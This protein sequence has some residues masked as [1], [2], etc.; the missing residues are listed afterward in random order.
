M[1]SPVLQFFAPSPS[2]RVLRSGSLPSMLALALFA[3]SPSARGVTS[4]P[5]GGYPNQNTAEG[6]N[7]L[8][9]LTSGNENTAIGFD[10][11][12]SNNSGSKNAATGAYALFS[13]RSA[14]NT[15]V[16]ARSLVSNTNG[17]WNTAI[18]DIALDSQMS[19]DYNLRCGVGALH[20]NTNGVANT[21]C[22][23]F[24]LYFNEGSSNSLLHCNFLLAPGGPPGSWWGWGSG[25]RGNRVTKSGLETV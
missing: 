20:E 19:G 10:T 14:G 1:Y 3:V 18:G 7:A 9:R 24:A 22:G 21:A 5:D 2:G 8:F 16:A 13:N 17:G 12:F 6:S 25:T 15:A 11:L 23:S 4:A